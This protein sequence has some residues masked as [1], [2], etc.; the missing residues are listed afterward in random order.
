MDDGLAYCILLVALKKFFP[1]ELLHLQLTQ[2]SAISLD[3]TNC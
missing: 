2:Q 3:K 1:T